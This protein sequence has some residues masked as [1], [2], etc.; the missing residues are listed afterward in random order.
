MLRAL[1]VTLI[2]FAIVSFILGGMMLIF[3][4]QTGALFNFPEFPKEGSGCVGS[5][6]LAPSNG[7]LLFTAGH[8]KLGHSHRS[9]HHRHSF[10]YCLRRAISEAAGRLANSQ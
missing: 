7:Y 10:F 8:N 3:P 5:P 9:G 6:C 2:V 4:D 1:K